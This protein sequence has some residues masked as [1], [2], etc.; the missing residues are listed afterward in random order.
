MD[1]NYNKFI[2]I[3]NEQIKLI[4]ELGILEATSTLL[5]N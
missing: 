2:N 3:Q 5:I 4:I 1:K